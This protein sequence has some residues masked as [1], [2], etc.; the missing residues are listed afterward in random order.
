MT[1][2]LPRCQATL[3]H[4]HGTTRCERDAFHSE[5]EL[6]GWGYGAELEEHVGRCHQCEEDDGF[7]SAPLS[8]SGYR[9]VWI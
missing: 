5:K 3:E 8:W 1:A 9:E 7:D 2:P 4:A 6:D